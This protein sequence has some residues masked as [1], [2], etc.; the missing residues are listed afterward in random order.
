MDT[1]KLD[2][3]LLDLMIVTSEEC[4]ELTQVCSKIIRKYNQIDKIDK[5]YSSRLLEEAGDV[6]CMIRLMVEHG[7]LKGKDLA[8]RVKV[9]KEKLKTWSDLV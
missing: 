9:K 5:E 6:L 2:K 3:K 7:L 4:G 1:R 8:A